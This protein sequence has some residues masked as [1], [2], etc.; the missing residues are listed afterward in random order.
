MVAFLADVIEIFRATVAD[1]PQIFTWERALRLPPGRLEGLQ[2]FKGQ[3]LIDL[4][5]F[6]YLLGS[7]HPL[8]FFPLLIAPKYS[9]K[10]SEI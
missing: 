1:P 4:K 9:S 10:Q 2:I 5:L 8:I 7:S 6:H 3:N